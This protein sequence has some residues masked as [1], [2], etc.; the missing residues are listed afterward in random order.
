[1]K[2][3][4]N[5]KRSNLPFW[6]GKT[7]CFSIAS[8]SEAFMEHLRTHY[9]TSLVLEIVGCWWRSV[10][11]NVFWCWQQEARSSPKFSKIFGVCDNKYWI[12]SRHETKHKR[13]AFS[14]LFQETNKGPYF[15][16]FVPSTPWFHNKSDQ[17]ILPWTQWRVSGEDDEAQVGTNPLAFEPDFERFSDE[18]RNRL[19]TI[20]RRTWNNRR[21]PMGQL[22][23]LESSRGTRLKFQS[24]RITSWATK[25]RRWKLRQKS[26]VWSP[27]VHRSHSQTVRL[28]PLPPLLL[29]PR[30][31]LILYHHR[32]I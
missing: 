26:P 15:I 10:C 32:V 28:V 17:I 1:M 8:V 6:V 12:P 31:K 7:H 25:H 14:F 29:L 5:K 30:Q 16:S 2:W 23:W 13:I 9:P 4:W 20:R 24:S 27:N 22:C 11:A 21:S 3:F 19:E 18:L